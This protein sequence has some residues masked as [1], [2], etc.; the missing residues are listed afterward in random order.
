MSDQLHSFSS[1]L[2]TVYARTILVTSDKLLLGNSLRQIIKVL[3]SSS[4]DETV[5]QIS[6]VI[7]RHSGSW[8]SLHHGGRPSMSK[9]NFMHPEN[10]TW[11]ANQF[12]KE[13]SS[14]KLV[15]YEVL[16]IGL[17]HGKSVAKGRKLAYPEKLSCAQS[18]PVQPLQH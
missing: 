13:T 14:T 10:V 2:Q 17:L 15:F 6:L 1:I 9:A 8:K 16:S 3:K 4:S 7:Q 11:I 5:I 18:I 12:Q